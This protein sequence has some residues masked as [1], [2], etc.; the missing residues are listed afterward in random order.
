[1]AIH[2]ITDHPE[3]LLKNLSK[4]ALYDSHW[5]IDKQNDISSGVRDADLSVLLSS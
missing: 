4:H 3:D 1:M 2:I 5:A